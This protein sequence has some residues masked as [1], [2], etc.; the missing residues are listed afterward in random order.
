[1]PSISATAL[2]ANLIV[3]G[4]GFVAFVYGKRLHAWPPM[5]IGLGLMVATYFVG[6]A[7]L[8]IGIGVVLTSALFFVRS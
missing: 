3:G 8:L 4:V 1:M 2:F 5:F 7:P 6:S